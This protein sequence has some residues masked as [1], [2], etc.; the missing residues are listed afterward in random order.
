MNPGSATDAA[1]RSLHMTHLYTIIALDIANERTR[2]AQ[3]ARR[4]ALAT[5]GLAPQPGPLRHGLAAG[6][7]F[8]SRGTAAAARRLDAVAADERAGVLATGK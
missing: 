7:A 8:V 3:E 5:Q 4:A 1:G 6:L 2:A